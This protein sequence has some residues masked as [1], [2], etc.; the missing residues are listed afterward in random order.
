MHNKKHM[1]AEDASHPRCVFNDGKEVWA[2]TDEEFV[3]FG[4]RLIFQRTGETRTKI[5]QRYKESWARLHPDEQVPLT[6]TG[7]PIDLLWESI[8]PCQHIPWMGGI[9]PSDSLTGRITIQY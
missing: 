4:A 2:T 8:H 3:K 1:C 5:I 9:P 6:S 7:E